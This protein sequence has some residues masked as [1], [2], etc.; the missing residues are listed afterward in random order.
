MILRYVTAFAFTLVTFSASAQTFCKVERFNY[1][2]GQPVSTTMK[3]VVATVPR[4]SSIP[5]R[6]AGNWCNLAF[7][8]G[9]PFYKPVEVTKKPASGEI[10]HGSYSVR[11]RAN[12][13]GTDT[14]TFVLHQ[15][16][17][18]SNAVRDTSVTVAVEVVAAP[19]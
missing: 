3:T 4:T 10:A 7:N 2:A 16:D 14:F 12:K 18:R 6:V 8:S 19:F 11:Y 9:N 17:A 15:L 5:G 13:V 1:V